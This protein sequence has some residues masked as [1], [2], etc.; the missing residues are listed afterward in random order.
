MSTLAIIVTVSLFGFIV[1]WILKDKRSIQSLRKIL[2]PVAPQ[3]NARRAIQTALR[4]ANSSQRATPMMGTGRIG[5]GFEAV[6][7]DE[8]RLGRLD[9]CRKGRIGRRTNTPHS[10]RA[11]RPSRAN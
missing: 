5:V 4:D 8:G 3:P 7:G 10:S 11:V 2:E 6:V 1:Y 9:F